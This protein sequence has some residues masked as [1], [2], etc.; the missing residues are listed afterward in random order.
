MR[1]RFATTQRPGSV[2]RPSAG[3][4]P[5]SRLRL[6]PQAALPPGRRAPP[7]LLQA[8]LAAGAPGLCGP[9]A[10]SPAHPGR[11]ELAAAFPFPGAL[12]LA[13]FPAERRLAT[14]WLAAG[15]ASPLCAKFPLHPGAA[16]LAEDAPGDPLAV[17]VPLR[18]GKRGLGQPQRA[19]PPAT[20][21]EGPGQVPRGLEVRDVGR[22][23]LPFVPGAVELLPPT[24][25]HVPAHGG[26]ASLA[27]LGG[28][29][30]ARS[31]AAGAA[32]CLL[33]LAIG[34][35]GRVSLAL[36]RPL[37]GPVVGIAV[38]NRGPAARADISR[39]RTARLRMTRHVPALPA[40]GIPWRSLFPEPPPAGAHVLAR[41]LAVPLLRFGRSL[42]LAFPGPPP[43]ARAEVGRA[44]ATRARRPRQRIAFTAR[45]ELLAQTVNL[46]PGCGV[47]SGLADRLAPPSL[48]GTGVTTAMVWPRQA[49][50]A[51]R[52]SA[53][54][55]LERGSRSA[56]PPSA[57]GH[58][59]RSVRRDG[60]D[61]DRADAEV[62]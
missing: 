50:V 7:R 1:T 46:L 10:V 60:H 2:P 49:P 51:L 56:R 43:A 38:A 15:H 54:R 37:P 17:E 36:S 6:F 47:R 62:P 14:G 42:R 53:R 55:G 16:T 20:G 25:A 45:G 23:G 9:S 19:A 13:A 4:C 29:G 26:P 41:P 32:G 61:G 8:V 18:G 27:L 52:S 28:A 31:A 33:G 57:A 59:E 48:K 5:Y 44:A 35:V 39:A 30:L 3:A 22:A 40:R 21:A 11:H 58:R 12:L 34:G 24:L